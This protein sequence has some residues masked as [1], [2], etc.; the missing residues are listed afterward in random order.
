MPLSLP[1]P[2]RLLPLLQKCKGAYLIWYNYLQDIPKTHRRS[3]GARID[4][5]FIETIEAIVSATFLPRTEKIPYVRL[6]T[7]KLDT[8]KILLMM[9]WETKSLDTKKYVALSM[10]LDEI[11]RML[12]GWNGQ[13][14]KQNSP[15]AVSREK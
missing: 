6:A 4:S 11:G 12:G 15:D 2:L 13:L 7:R 1:P 5:L 8:L 3:L 9:L 10:P 14:Q